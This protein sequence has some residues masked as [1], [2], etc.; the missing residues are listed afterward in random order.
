MIESIKNMGF[1]QYEISNFGK[2]C[3]H[4]LAYWKG[5][6]YHGFGAFAVGFYGACRK[7]GA[8]NISEYIKNPFA[9]NIENLSQSDLHLERLF[10]GLRSIV[11]V[12]KDELSPKELEKAQILVSAN[13][14]RYEKSRFFNNDYLLSDEITLYLSQI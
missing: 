14:L 2:I 6:S 9:K 10:L 1:N 5:E 7:M 3:E 8:K 11:G 4:N 13:K 12:A